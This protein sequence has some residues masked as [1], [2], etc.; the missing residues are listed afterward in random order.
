M[1]YDYFAALRNAIS[2]QLEGMYLSDIILVLAVTALLVL[3]PGYI[4]IQKHKDMTY[5]GLM[6][7]YFLMAYMGIVLVITIF[8]RGFG[9]KEGKIVTYIWLGS[10]TSSNY[11]ITQM[12]YCALNVLLFVPFGFLVRLNRRNEPGIKA[13]IMTFLSSFMFTFLIESFQ[14]ATRSGY[15]ELTDIVTN[16]AGGIIGAALGAIFVTG[17]RG[18]RE[19]VKKI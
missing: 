17:V 14:F 9:T 12:M 11:S 4:R 7:R 16:L 6:L 15:F 1:R 13:F 10:F 5:K 8:R 2:S 18:K 3:V 19:N